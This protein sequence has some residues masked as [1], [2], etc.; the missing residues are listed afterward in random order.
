MTEML[1]MT[2]ACWHEI[3]M[4]NNRNRVHG[5]I[6]IGDVKPRKFC[7]FPVEFDNDLDGD[8]K[9]VGIDTEKIE[10]FEK[11][12]SSVLDK[13]GFIDHGTP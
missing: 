6:M 11:L 1:K 9:L 7:G 12:I 4:N 13:I 8:F 5:S 10:V 2:E 3:E